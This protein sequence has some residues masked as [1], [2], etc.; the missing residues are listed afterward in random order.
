[1]IELTTMTAKALNEAAAVQDPDR[2]GTTRLIP[3]VHLPKHPCRYSIEQCLHSIPELK[4]TIE[5]DK[6]LDDS[7]KVFLLS[8][9]SKFTSNA[10]ELDLHVVDQPQGGLS[11]HIHIA[12]RHL[13]ARPKSARD[14]KP[15]NPD[16]IAEVVRAVG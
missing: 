14:P 4:A 16:L 5:A 13:G 9:L 3:Q 8:E 7:L 6:E 12:A 1:M 10:A 2:P 11:V 15:L